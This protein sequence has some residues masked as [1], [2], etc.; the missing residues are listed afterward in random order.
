LI[1]RTGARY[2]DR[3]LKGAE[4]AELPVQEIPKIEFAI[5][6]ETA[7]RLGLKVPQELMI[8]ADERYP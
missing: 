4:P 3:L 7:A 5:N 1:G 6:R 2:V 8:Q